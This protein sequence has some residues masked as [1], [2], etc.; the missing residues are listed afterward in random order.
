MPFP[1]LPDHALQPPPAHSPTS[2]IWKFSLR[3][4]MARPRYENVAPGSAR[5]TFPDTCVYEGMDH[6]NY[7]DHWTPTHRRCVHT[8]LRASAL[9]PHLERV[10]LP[11]TCQIIQDTRV[12]ICLPLACQSR[13]P[14]FASAIVFF[15]LIIICWSC[16]DHVSK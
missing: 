2:V 7:V 11:Q 10:P 3:L 4:A 5:I 8:E 15:T 14:H 16:F 12:T 9:K 13:T 6:L 1:F